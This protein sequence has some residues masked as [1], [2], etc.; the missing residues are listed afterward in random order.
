MRRLLSHAFSDAALREQEQL[1]TQYLDL[2]IE[3]LHEQIV[4]TAQGKIDFVRWYN[5]TTFDIL[6]DLCFDESFGALR[7]GQYHSWV[8]NIFKSMKIARMFRVFR[9]YP[10][11]GKFVFTLLKLFPQ[12]TKAGA[13]HRA[14]TAQKTERRLD[15]PTDRKDFM[16]FALHCPDRQYDFTKTISVSYILR[17]ND[18]KG[19]TRDEIKA[20]SGILV[21]AGSETTATLLSGATFLLL[22]NPSSLSKAVNEVRKSFVQASDI[23]FASVT[24]QL[25]YLNACLEESLRLYPPVPSV[26]PRRTGPDGDIING[27]FVPPDVSKVRSAKGNAN[28]CH[29]RPPLAS[30]PGVLT[31][32]LPTSNTHKAS[33]PSVGLATSATPTT[34][35]QHASPSPSG[36]EAVLER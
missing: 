21:I 19:M 20:T 31:C 33:P 28:K 4:G 32:P 30:T 1:I 16:R 29:L 7:N 15:R 27:R 34:T 25:P 18:E 12:A 22:K 23:T 14:L 35:A 24:A 2:L 10:I 6:G 5:F 8:A 3:K 36:R 17:Y 26:L 9:A 13:E 11:F